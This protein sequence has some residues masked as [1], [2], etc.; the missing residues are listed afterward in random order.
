MTVLSYHK[1]RIKKFGCLW[2]CSIPHPHTDAK[3][4][5]G[6]GLSPMGAYLHFRIGI[7]YPRNW[8]LRLLQEKGSDT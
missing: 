2:E 3:R 6:Y 1:P 8:R 4:I 7:S 5:V